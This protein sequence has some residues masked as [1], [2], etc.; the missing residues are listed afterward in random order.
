M[1]IFS[2]L[3]LYG[4]VMGDDDAKGALRAARAEIKQLINEIGDYDYRPSEEGKNTI[5]NMAVYSGGTPS[6]GNYTLTATRADGFTKTT[7]NIVYDDQPVNLKSH[8]DTMFY[9]VIPGYDFGHV[10]VTG[11]P[12]LDS[13][14]FVVNFS[15]SSVRH[16]R[17][18]LTGEDL[19]LTPGTLGAITSTQ[20]GQT[21]RRAWAALFRGSVIGPTYP[22]QG[23]AT[24]WTVI[25]WPDN[26]S[27]FRLSQST[28]KLLAKEASIDD[29][30][31][32]V[33]T[34]LM[35]DFGIQV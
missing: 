7:A 4:K 28:L 27:C 20:T 12:N 24:G 29:D 18:T 21:N 11:G 9:G 15:G 2:D 34:N 33:F 3:L 17:W 30:N 22:A 6:S 8:F 10:N 26:N 16:Q 25:P 35:A 32:A 31:P 14:P 19:D 23:D 13:V 5:Y 1:G